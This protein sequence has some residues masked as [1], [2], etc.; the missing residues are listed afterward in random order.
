LIFGEFVMRHLVV[1]L[2]AAALP[3]SAMASEELAKKAGCTACHAVDKKIIGPSYK[4]VAAKYKGD[5]KAVEKLAEKVKKGGAGAWGAVP[6]P[7]HPALSDADN[8]A[9][10]KWVMAAKQFRAAC[11]AFENKTRLV[12][13]FVLGRV[14]CKRGSRD[15]EFARSRGGL[16]RGVANRGAT[17]RVCRRA[18][19]CA[20][21]AMRA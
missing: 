12:R 2:I 18:G 16:R 17:L 19:L 15:A 3:F 11:F 20:T 6:M 9:I 8:T 7:P 21:L 4:D 10:I 13:V 1:S 5:A 14:V